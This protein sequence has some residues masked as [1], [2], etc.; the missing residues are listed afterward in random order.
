MDRSKIGA[1]GIGSQQRDYFKILLEK[2]G[3]AAFKEYIMKEFAL[4]L[5]YHV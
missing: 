4:R 5:M 2:I 1:F 3:P